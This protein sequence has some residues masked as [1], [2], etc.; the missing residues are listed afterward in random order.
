MERA[1]VALFR[2]PFKLAGFALL[3]FSLFLSQDGRCDPPL[4][5]DRF[6]I[7]A[8]RNFVQVYERAREDYK[9]KGPEAFMRYFT[10]TQKEREFMMKLLG[11]L[12]PLPLLSMD[13]EVIMTRSKKYQDI[14]VK[15]VKDMDSRAIY[16]INGVTFY[17]SEKLDMTQ[18][19]DQI[20]I[21]SKP[22]I[23]KLDLM[24]LF[25]P[26]AFA[27][28][29]ILPPVAITSLAVS[30]ANRGRSKDHG[31]SGIDVGPGPDHDPAGASRPRPNGK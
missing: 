30:T 6:F 12:P 2:G 10:F 8:A 1:K 28:S 9:E 22:R 27:A 31:T 16:E 20:K 18:I 7:A 3:F 13:G 11:D 23:V 17:I 14:R 5:P 19:Y 4:P 24:G 21:I 26:S 29:D 15:K 25:I